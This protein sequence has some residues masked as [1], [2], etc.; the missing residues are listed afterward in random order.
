MSMINCQSYKPL[1]PISAKYHHIIIVILWTY[2]I[3]EL[4]TQCSDIS[5]VSA[6]KKKKKKELM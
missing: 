5:I 2:Y 4:Y 6:K 1:I 3:I